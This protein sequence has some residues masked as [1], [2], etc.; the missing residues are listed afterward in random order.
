MQ[1]RHDQALL[2]RRARF[3]FLKE[4]FVRKAVDSETPQEKNYLCGFTSSLA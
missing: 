2:F 1:S 4:K 3:Y